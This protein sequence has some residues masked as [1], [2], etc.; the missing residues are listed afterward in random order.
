MIPNKETDPEPDVVM[1]WRPGCPSCSSLRRELDRMKLPY[2]A[3]DIWDDSDA[4]A[5]VRS[6]AHG[7]E[8]VPTVAVGSTAM[9]N[10][11]AGQVRDAVAPHAPHLVP[12]P[13][14]QKQRGLGRW[15][16]RA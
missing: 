10:P 9:V 14:P 4:A 13:A 1:Y 6:V 7:N 11:S 15:F 2:K 12:E 16:R 5:F 8:T 3:V